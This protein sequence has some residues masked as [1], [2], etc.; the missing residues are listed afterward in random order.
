MFDITRAPAANRPTA[1][2]PPL[3]S[4]MSAASRK[5][6]GCPCGGFCPRCTGHGQALSQPLRASMESGLRTSFADVRVHADE[7][8][9]QMAAQARAQ[10]FTIGPD[11]FFGAGR[12]APHTTEGATRL[13]HEL[14]HVEQ[15]RNGQRD[16]A[17]ASAPSAE[18]EARELGAAVATGARVNVRSAAPRVMQR[19]GPESEGSTGPA[20]TPPV[21]PQLQL[22]PEI[23]RM[24]LQHYIR[25]WLGTTLVTGDAPST[26]PAAPDPDAYSDP[27]VSADAPTLP[28]I[29]GLPP[30]PIWSQLPL[31]PPLFAPLPPDSLFL[32]PDVG[33]LFSGFGQRGAPVGAGDSEVV[34]D[35]YR[36]N[37]AIARGLPDLRG[38]APRFLQPLIPLT[39]RRDIAGALTGAAIGAGLNRDYM[40]PIE[41]SDQAFQGMTGAS[42]T[43]IP[44]P[45]ISFDLD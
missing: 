28:S 43:V 24:M 22:D 2:R 5:P 42:T 26:L 7:G 29:P 38:M 23:K 11:I 30:A 13:A 32:E 40:T 20:L 25:W 44:L 16:G 8:A 34:F 1:S 39:W 36:R 4:A 14:V 9:A 15:Q 37:A 35:I 10:A 3:R 41:V 21:G 18:R 17:P 33:S 12:F 19:D 45:S 31:T 6:T 27:E